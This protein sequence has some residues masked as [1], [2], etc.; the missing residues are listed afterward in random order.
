MPQLEN[1]RHEWFAQH[2][3]HGH[4]LEEAYERAGYTPDRGHAC[5]LASRPEVAERINEIRADFT[6]ITADRPRVIHALMS[7]GQACRALETPEG[8]KEARFTY[9]EAARLQQEILDDMARDRDI[10]KRE[11]ALQA[12]P[13]PARIAAAEP[14]SAMPERG[15][16]ALDL[17][18]LAEEAG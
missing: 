6:Q 12:R 1:R 18:D 8:L 9:L 13:A 7:V 5:R 14:A 17:H 15:G 3:A 4:R 2:R 16:N 11:L 10:M